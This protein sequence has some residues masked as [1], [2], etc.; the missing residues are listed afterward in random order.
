[1][2]LFF[3]FFRPRSWRS[4]SVWIPLVAVGIISCV[5]LSL[6]M[7]FRSGALAQH[8]I[9]TMRDGGSGFAP[10]TR[11]AGEPPLRSTWPV[12]T[13]YR[14]LVATVFWGEE[15]QQLD[16]PGIPNVEASG[17]V[18]AS[19]AV[20]AQREDD[21]TGEIGGWLGDRP[22]RT[23]PRKALAHPREMVIVEFTDTVSPEIASK[24]R[25]QPIRDVEGYAP[26]TGFVIV[27]L[28]ILAL[29]S[30]ALARAGAAVHHNARSR[31]YSLLRV[32]GAPPRQLA[33]VIASDMAIPMLVGALVGSVAYAV[34]MSSLDSFTVAGNSYWASDLVLPVTLALALPLVVVLV[35]LVSVVRMILR[36]GRDPVGTLRRESKPPSYLTYIS[37]VGIVAGPAAVFVSPDAD[38]TLAPLLL[39]GGMLLSVVGLEGLSRV[40]VAA[41]GKLLVDQTRAQVAGSRMSRSGAEALLGV[42]ATSVAVLLIVFSVYANVLNLPPPTGDFDVLA[43]LPNLESSGPIVRA[44]EDIDGVARVVAVGRV[45]V[46][47]VQLGYVHTMTCEDARGSVKLDAPCTAGSIYLGQ[48]L[49]DIDTVTLAAADL[50]P[51]SNS[52]PTDESVPGTYP[53]GGRVDASWITLERSDVVLMVDQPPIPHHTLLLV[54]TDGSP[55]S[56]RRVMEGLRSRPEESYPFTRAALEAGFLVPGDTNS[57]RLVLLPYLFV[58]ATAAAAMAA[59]ALL[60]AVLLLFRQRQAEFRMLRSQGA[61]R[62]LL[63]VDLSVLFAAPLTLAFGLAVASGAALAA[64]YNTA[65]GVPA[66]QLNPQ[67]ISVL[68]FVLAIGLAA[69]ALVAARAIRIPPLVA[70]P[71]TATA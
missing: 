8:D 30:I 3:R 4:L 69:T 56:L 48:G 39:I 12:A 38:P 68:A 13:G 27:G 66:P 28:L 7:G 58:M 11:T 70:D 71:D 29:P 54:T 57:I 40:A 51:G 14:P 22:V 10:R 52:S 16:L 5:G 67:A 25:F 36:A 55:G 9:A 33:A 43:E 21:W 23:L 2:T 6:A 53:V 18:L 44:M 46:D 45:L 60:Y 62:L 17:T 42:S 41:L 1:M 24:A 15:G 59:V 19:P 64:S 61:T 47:S 65:N 32:L 31:R 35:G 34:F 37:A 49:P 63:A 26:E 50:L 20:L